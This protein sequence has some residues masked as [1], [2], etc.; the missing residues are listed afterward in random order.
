M[1]L[2]WD[3]D[4]EDLTEIEY[5]KKRTSRVLVHDEITAPMGDAGNIAPSVSPSGPPTP[6]EPAP[7]PFF[8]T[9]ALRPELRVFN[10]APLRD[11]FAAFFLDSILAFYLYWLI[12]FGLIKF[13]G[14]PSIF[15]LHQ[16]AGRTAMHLALTAAVVFLYYVLMESVFGATLGKFFC[17][18]RVIDESG[19]NAS[20][21]NIFIRNFLRLVDYPL[22]FLIAVIA[23]ESSPLNQRLG[24][25][26]A[27]TLVIKKTRRHLRPLDLSHT[28]LA[29]TLSRL[30]AEGIDL[31][32][33]LT[34]LY[35]FL[36][37]MKPSRPLLSY[38]MYLSI[39]LVFIFYYTLLEFF[40]GTTPGKTLFK[41]QVVLD[42]GEPPD[43]TSSLIRNLLKPVDYFL[44]YPLMVLSKYKQ[45]LGDLAAD[46]LVVA[47]PAGQ[48]G[49]MGSAAALLLVLVVAYLG[50]SNP[51]NFI[52]KDYGLSPLEGI[53]IFLPPYRFRP[54]TSVRTGS[55]ASSKQPGDA[56]A[57]AL[58]PSTSQTLQ[59][60]EFYFAAGPTPAQI[61]QDTVFRVGDLVYAFFKVQGFEV[62]SE[63]EASITED[64]V[65]EDPTGAVVI[66]LPRIVEMTKA[67]DPKTPGILFANHLKFP[68]E[69]GL[70]KYRAVFTVMDHVAEKQLAFEKFFEVK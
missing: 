66:E 46:T 40:T 41:R 35:G 8:P 11:R 51:D 70:G 9:P 53:K 28:P 15:V 69:L 5:K 27:K 52:R 1:P 17:R 10:P 20:L 56:P 31:L 37:M 7:Q 63:G 48:K 47:K 64:V 58:P 43:G 45:R 30:F 68:K 14:M 65:V 50:F 24:D 12:G 59:L 55:Q 3:D 22:L 25:R 23:M 44:G 61:R 13:F 18:L 6:V 36:L 39:P 19:Q 21:G 26:A 32:L 4:E 60:A 49:V 33:A 67:I 34:L 54:K 29:S 57:T 62:N 2:Y 38:V 42:N 16:T